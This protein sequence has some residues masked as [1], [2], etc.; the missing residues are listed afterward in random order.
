MKRSHRE[1]KGES[2][3][4]HDDAYMYHQH[5]SETKKAGNGGSASTI[6]TSPAFISHS[7][8]SL[9]NKP[10]PDTY[11]KYSPKTY[12]CLGPTTNSKS[13]HFTIYWQKQTSFTSFLRPKVLLLVCLQ[14]IL[15]IPLPNQN[16]HASL[17]WASR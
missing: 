17:C 15:P 14:A 7:I 11:S 2:D 4:Q 16:R 13:F 3:D 8:G 9:E 6:G 1:Q 12:L 5:N 10:L